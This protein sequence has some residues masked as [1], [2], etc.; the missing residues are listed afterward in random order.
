M[1]REEIKEYIVCI[2][3]NQGSVYGIRLV[4]ELLSRG[5]RVHLL[6][7]VQSHQWIDEL[8][9]RYKQQFFF[10]GGNRISERICSGSGRCDGMVIVPCPTEIMR[11]ILEEQTETMAVKCADMCRKQRKEL[12]IVP[13]QTS[14]EQ[15][16][17]ETMLALVKSGVRMISATPAFDQYAKTLEETID[18]TVGK[19]LDGLYI[20]QS[21]GREK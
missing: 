19:I 20:E 15:Q 11:Q 16:Q 1:E 7:D 9:D 4:A 2:P 13:Q 3:C 21:I 14:L 10:E 17:L 12:V 5:Y 8:K 18:L 6:W